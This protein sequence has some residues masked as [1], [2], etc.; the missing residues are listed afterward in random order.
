MLGRGRSQADAHLLRDRRIQ[1]LR[2]DARTV[3][4]TAPDQMVIL[5]RA[6][7]ALVP[8]GRGKPD[9]ATNIGY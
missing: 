8:S 9:C 3:R 2:A 5:A 1:V 7:T 4:H 6:C